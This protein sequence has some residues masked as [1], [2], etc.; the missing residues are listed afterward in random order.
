MPKIFLKAMILKVLK[1][2]LKKTTFYIEHCSD[3]KH[4]KKAMLT[5]IFYPYFGCI[6][7][8]FHIS[9]SSYLTVDHYCYYLGE[10]MHFFA[11][12][13]YACSS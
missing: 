7:I 6:I 1:G 9:I 13:S 5:C 2:Y 11:K 8:K 12:Y 3:I 10:T 4:C